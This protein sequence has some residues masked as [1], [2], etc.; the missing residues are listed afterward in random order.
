MSENKRLSPDELK[1]VVGLTD[2][3]HKNRDEYADLS[4]YIERLRAKKSILLKK[5]EE[6]E[7]LLKECHYS[8]TSKYGDVAFDFNDGSILEKEDVK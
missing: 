5:F 8:L 4:I 1:E 2:S 6:S 7:H 3:F